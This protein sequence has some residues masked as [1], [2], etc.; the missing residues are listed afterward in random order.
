MKNVFALVQM[1]MYQIV[2]TS[3]LAEHGVDATVVHVYTSV[4][5]CSYSMLS[6]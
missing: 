5:Y 4:V 6:Q 3:I 2:C 1:Y